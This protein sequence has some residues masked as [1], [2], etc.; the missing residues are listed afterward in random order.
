MYAKVYGETTCAVSM[1]NRSLS[2][3]IFLTGCRALILWVCLI[4]QSK[5]LGNGYGLH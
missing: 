2:K 4:R 1:V 3:W 5:N